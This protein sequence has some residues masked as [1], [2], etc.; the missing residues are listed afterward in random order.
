MFSVSI[1]VRSILFFNATKGPEINSGQ[2][3]ATPEFELSVQL[4]S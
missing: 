2:V 3:I 1:S 4:T